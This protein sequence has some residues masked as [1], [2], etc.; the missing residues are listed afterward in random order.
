M[1]TVTT[2]PNVRIRLHDDPVYKDG[3]E[4]A[5]HWLEWAWRDLCART[6]GS[7]EHRTLGDAHRQ[8][9][10]T[11][12]IFSSVNPA[13]MRAARHLAALGYPIRAEKTRISG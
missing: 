6:K 8:L 10:R 4:L 5:I 13:G 1:K 2:D 7:H 3:A 11:N 9:D 12:I